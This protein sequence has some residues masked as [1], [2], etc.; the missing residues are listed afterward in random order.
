MIALHISI[1]RGTKC[2]QHPHAR[3]KTRQTRKIA[4]LMT[5]QEM[6]YPLRDTTPARTMQDAPYRK[7]SAADDI[8]RNV[9]CPAKYRQT[10]IVRCAHSCNAP[11]I[12]IARN[13]VLPGVQAGYRT[14]CDRCRSLRPFSA[15]MTCR[16]RVSRTLP[17][18]AFT[19]DDQKTS[20]KHPTPKG[21][22][23]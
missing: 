11:D 22:H 1:E 16:R 18:R 13:K 20:V 3:C 8:T 19:T 2:A 15:P 21:L 4:L 17:Q 23:H 12:T 10:R 9:I 6:R 5:S 14:S 7:D